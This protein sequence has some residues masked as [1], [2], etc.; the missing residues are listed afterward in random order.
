MS[1]QEHESSL[2]G[3]SDESAYTMEQKTTDQEKPVSI[4]DSTCTAEHEGRQCLAQKYI[5]ATRIS[6][7][8]NDTRVGA[9]HGRSTTNR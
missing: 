4:Y 7:D 3:S 8:C 1:Y 6:P 9:E 2:S 5:T